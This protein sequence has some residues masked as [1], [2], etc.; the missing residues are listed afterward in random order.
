LRFYVATQISGK[1]ASGRKAAFL[2]FYVAT[3]ISGK[4]ASGRKAA[5]LRFYVATQKK[6]K[7]SL[8]KM[9][10]F[11]C[12]I[13][14]SAAFLRFLCSRSIME[15]TFIHLSKTRRDICGGAGK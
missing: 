15:S 2:R 5:F 13:F 10:S 3:Q 1:N 14:S 6:R 4:N 9:L 12:I 8:R 11:F 7:K